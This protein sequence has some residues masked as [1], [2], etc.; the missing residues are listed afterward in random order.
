MHTGRRW[1]LTSFAKSTSRVNSPWPA[2]SP[3]DLGSTRPL[4]PIRR[5]LQ[6]AAVAAM[7]KSGRSDLAPRAVRECGARVVLQALR[8]TP[9]AIGDRSGAWVRAA[10]NDMSAVAQYLAM[11]QAI[12]RPILHMLARALPPDAVPNDFGSDPWLNALR[13]STGLI[14][15]DATFYLAAYLL[16]RALGSRS[17]LPGELAQLSLE[18]AHTAAA[19]NRLPEEGWRLLE[20]R[21]PWSAFSFEWD[22][23][24]RLRAGVTNLF[25]DRDLSPVL[26]AHLTKN[27]DLLLMLASGAARS[28]RGRSYLKRVRRAMK[29]EG[30]AA[31]NGRICDLEKLP[32]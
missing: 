6:S 32:G 3:P 28:G 18:R 21:L 2:W 4:S 17:R 16:S 1:V 7:L 13:N 31:L 12:P 9:D 29:D 15:D 10:A 26:F 19:S 25:I 5:S 8:D 22:R 27:D 11:Q 30:N 23:C 14:D 24:Q 20:S